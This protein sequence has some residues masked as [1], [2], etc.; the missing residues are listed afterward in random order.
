ML[1][2]KTKKHLQVR[3]SKYVFG[4]C[5]GRFLMIFVL[6]DSLIRS[7]QEGVRLFE[8]YIRYMKW[9]SW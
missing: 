4:L 6:M 5:F 2:T 8:T 1:P 7:L 3:S 9:L